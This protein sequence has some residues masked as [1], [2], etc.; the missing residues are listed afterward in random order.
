[1]SSNR[2]KEAIGR[3]LITAGSLALLGAAYQGLLRRRVVDWGATRD[4]AANRIPGHELLDAIQ[5]RAARAVTIDAPP[6]AIWPWLVQMG[7]GDGG[8]RMYD[9]IER[10]LW[11]DVRCADGTT[12]ELHGLHEADDVRSRPAASDPVVH[13]EILEPVGAMTTRSEDGTW[14]WTF[15]LVPRDASAR[16]SGFARA[17]VSTPDDVVGW[18]RWCSERG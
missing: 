2:S 15:V 16:V 10:L 7:S 14:V 3:A 4:E 5:T 18:L 13:I 12:S 1:M 6:E 17:S 8:A 11:L 9:W